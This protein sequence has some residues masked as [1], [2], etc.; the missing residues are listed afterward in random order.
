MIDRE[1]F[2]YYNSRYTVLGSVV[3]TITGDEFADYMTR[4]SSS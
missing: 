1:R 4:T 3:E 2:F